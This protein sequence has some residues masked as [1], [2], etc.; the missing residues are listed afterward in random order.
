MPYNELL[1]RSVQSSLEKTQQML[2]EL[3]EAYR[4]GVYTTRESLLEAYA[5]AI[6]R[7][8]EVA[9]GSL[10]EYEEVLPDT[11]P[12][13]QYQNDLIRGL[14]YD[15]AILFS[16][17]N[18]LGTLM[19][20]TFN[21]VVSEADDL[22]GRIRRVSSKLGD[23]EL[24]SG[25]GG[26][27]VGE[28][29]IN[30][31][32]LALGSS[33]AL[34]TEAEV[35]TI[36]GTVTL[37][38]AEES[39]LEIES[40]ILDEGFLGK[41]G[42]N[43]ETGVTCAHAVLTDMTD[44]NPNTW[45][46]FEKVWFQDEDTSPLSLRLI[47]KLKEEAILNRL[48]IDP[49]NF[50]Q[51]SG[52]VIEE[53]SVS[54]TGQSWTS[55]KGDIPTADYLGESDDLLYVLSPRAS[56]YK[57]V[58]S[59]T[60]LPRK[61][62]YVSITLRQDSG[63]L[64]ETTAGYKLRYVIGL[65]SVSLYSGKY[66]GES[67]LI[68]AP[69]T[70]SGPISKMAL[71][72]AYR[73]ISSSLG[74][75]EFGISFDSG[76]TWHAIQPLTEDDMSAAEV[77]DANAATDSFIYRIHL[78]R[79]T[80]AFQQATSLEEGEEELATTFESL[81]VSTQSSTARLYPSKQ[82]ASDSI[83]VM[84][85]PIGSCGDEEGGRVRF[86]LGVGTGDALSVK[87]P[88]S[89]VP[90]TDIELEDIQ[91]YVGGKE[92]SQLDDQAD[93]DAADMDAE[94][95][96]ISSDGY[97]V[98]GDG[99]PRTDTGNGKS[100]QA[101]AEISLSL[102][103]MDL[104]FEEVEGGWLA[105]LDLTASGNTASTR[106]ERVALSTSNTSEILPKGQTV[107][108][109]KNRGI[110]NSSFFIAERNSSGTIVPDSFV[111]EVATRSAVNSTGEYYIDY[112]NG[113]IYSYDEVASDKTTTVSYRYFPRTEVTDYQYTKDDN[114]AYA[115]ILISADKFVTHA[116]TDTT[117]TSVQTRTPFGFDGWETL[118]LIPS[119][120]VY[121]NVIQ[122]SQDRIIKGS[123]TIPT[124]L[125]GGA[126]IPE[127]VDYIDGSSELEKLLEVANETVAET[128]ATG[129][130]SFTL[131]GGSRVYAGTGVVFSDAAIFATETAV[132]PAIVGEY[133]ITYATGLIEVF[134]AAGIPAGVTAT[135]YTT[136][137]SVDTS[138]FYSVDHKRG[139]VYCAS[140]PQTGKDISYLYQKYRIHYVVARKLDS[141]EYTIDIEGNSISIDTTKFI[142]GNTLVSYEYNPSLETSLTE[143]AEYYTPLVRDL[144]FRVLTED[145]VT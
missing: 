55:I 52:I 111:T 114:G 101:G 8:R 81:Q 35:N 1:T 45:T 133:R 46:E 115:G 139:V 77:I 91:V 123:L 61:A 58:F 67:A 90:Y 145:M 84:N 36:E 16:E 106:V 27:S 72:A 99:S 70:V 42:N 30:T 124:D 134:L 22:A 41:V 95:Y 116:W 96:Y 40:V 92:W 142:N 94:V 34:P 39:L 56:L 12:M 14:A 13:V 127:E 122:L 63:F 54:T 4:T 82:I 93:L 130:Y 97:I 132:A 21:Q 89:I 15:L 109:L 10:Y 108:T 3:V 85:S 31:G 59:Y 20:S 71:L 78:I 138:G 74:T 23:Y 87:L 9:K 60:F 103:P 7:I 19:T 65:K 144:R 38:C 5:N 83:I 119:S 33:L 37:L 121:G 73:P 136:D 98:F 129:L 69:R 18:S 53:I 113:I 11:E 47:F 118:G 64:I 112:T 88:F 6:N 137:D 48:Q 143:L 62:R 86:K 32:N 125:F 57:G 51:L 43:E 117:S 24:I 107:C 17:M 80:S 66:T 128:S 44:E 135:Y 68:S 79:N 25:E 120:L 141:G 131:S 2:L 105:R 100:P 104:Y 76:S 49:V 28:S 140:T 110:D 102:A 29:F 50:G 26:V 126:I 75:V